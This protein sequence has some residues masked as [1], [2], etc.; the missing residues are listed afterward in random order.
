MKNLKFLFLATIGILSLGVFSSCNRE[1]SSSVDQDK[2]WAEYELFYNAN[3]D[4]TYARAKF[5]FSNAL[6]TSLELNEAASITFDG[7]V[8]DWKPLLAYYEKDYAGN[9]TTGNFEYTDIDGSVFVNTVTIPEIGYPVGL[10]TIPRDAAFEF[11]W[12]GTALAPDEEVALTING[13]LEGD[14]QLFFQNDDGATS[15]ILAKN[16]LEQLG[17]GEGSLWLDRSFKPDIDQATSA[18]GNLIGRYR[19]VNQTVILQ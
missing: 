13:V 15:I 12:T 8:L 4:K 16:Q 5:R 3:E 17:A 2:I 6:G 18:G 11:T 9:L 7:E 10:D 14:A 1:D 19:P